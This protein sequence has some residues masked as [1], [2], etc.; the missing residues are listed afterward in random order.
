MILALVLSLGINTNVVNQ[1]SPSTK[2]HCPVF[3]TRSQAVF[4]RPNSSATAFS[5]ILQRS[6]CYTQVVSPLQAACILAGYK[7]SKCKL[8]TIT[9]IKSGRKK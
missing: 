6:M 1:P 8:R 4:G 3:L 9:W 2:I 7:E 5:A